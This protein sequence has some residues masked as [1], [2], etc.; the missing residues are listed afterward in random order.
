MSKQTLISTEFGDTSMA[1][2]NS[3][4]D[5]LYTG[6]ALDSEVVHLA[7]AEQISN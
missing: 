2:I 7:G 3:N 4:F 5:E 6:K 1:K